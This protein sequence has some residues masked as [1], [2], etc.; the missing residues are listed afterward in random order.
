MI[1]KTASD[2]SDIKTRQIQHKKQVYKSRFGFLN[3]HFGVR[4]SSFTGLMGT[5]GSGK[6]T[7][8]KSII[9]DC[10]ATHKVNCYLTEEKSE[11]YEMHLH[12]IGANMGNISFIEENESAFQGMDCEGAIAMLLESLFMCE[13]DIIFLD[14]ITTSVLYEKYQYNGQT[15]L[16]SALRAFCNDTGKTVFYIAHTKKGSD[17][18]GHRLFTGDDIRGTSQAFQQA[19]YFYILQPV[20]VGEQTFPILQ[21]SKHRFHPKIGGKFFLLGYYED[22]Y[23]SDMRLTWDKVKDIFKK[24]NTLK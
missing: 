22:Q 6:S 19:E 20:N 14:N 10:A 1:E 11:D 18:N 3:A 16:I 7:L 2:V 15:R 8:I 21:V 13:S 4:P 17:N 24:R 12:Q 23:K 9:S 5:A